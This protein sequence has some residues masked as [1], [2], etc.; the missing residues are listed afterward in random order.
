MHNTLSIRHEWNINLPSCTH[1]LVVIYLKY[2]IVMQPAVLDT[3]V[4]LHGN[5]IDND[6]FHAQS[7]SASTA[8]RIQGNRVPAVCL[9]ASKRSF[10]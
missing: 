5:S 6:I 1:I 8:Q 4:L 3:N 7:L 10:P 2:R 9:Y